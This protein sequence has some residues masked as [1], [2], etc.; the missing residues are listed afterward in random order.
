MKDNFN[1]FHGFDFDGI[2]LRIGSMNLMLHSIEDPKIE[3]RDSLSEDYSGIYD[4][5]KVI[6]GKL[7]SLEAEISSDLDALEKM[8]S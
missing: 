6:L 2:M 4:P 8:L 7:R 5:P 1:M 3:A